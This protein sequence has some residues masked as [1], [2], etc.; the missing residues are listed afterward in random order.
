MEEFINRK[1]IRVKLLEND[2]LQEDLSELLGISRQ[3]LS[4]KMNGKRSF[5]EQEIAVLVKK[6]GTDIFI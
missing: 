6:F 1:K 2:L 5:S 3:N 4:L